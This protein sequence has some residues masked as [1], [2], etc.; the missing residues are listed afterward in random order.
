MV[1]LD[2]YRQAQRANLVRAHTGEMNLLPGIRQT[3]CDLLVPRET[4]DPLE[5]ALERLQAAFDR[6]PGL[7]IAEAGS[8]E[9]GQQTANRPDFV[10]QLSASVGV[11]ASTVRESRLPDTTR[12]VDHS[13]ALGL[14]RHL[15]HL[16]F[17]KQ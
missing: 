4:A 14:V 5:N 9:T 7:R 15:S 8:D 11:T 2:A 12:A 1:R 16:L 6:D 13:Q 17:G 3:N 10:D